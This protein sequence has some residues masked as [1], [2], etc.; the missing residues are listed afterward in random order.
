MPAASTKSSSLVIDKASE[1]SDAVLAL[2]KGIQDEYGLD[3]AQRLD[4]DGLSIHIPGVVSTGSEWLDWALGRGGVAMSRITLVSGNEG[5]GK[6]TLCL[7]LVAAVQKMGGVAFYVDAEYKLDLDYA[8]A[9]GVDANQMILSQPKTVEGAFAVID[10]ACD[11]VTT[12]RLKTG[13]DVPTLIILDSY[14]ALPAMVEVAVGKDK[15]GKD[16]NPAGKQ[17]PGAQARAISEQLRAIT[18]KLSK[19]HIALVLISQER[20]VFAGGAGNG[21]TTTGGNA[22]RF[23]AA[24][25]VSLE[26]AGFEKDGDE[27]IGRMT[28]VKVEKN[29]VGPPFRK[30]NLLLNYGKGIDYVH[31]L[32]HA[33]KAMFPEA[34]NGTWVHF[35]GLKW[36]GEQQLKQLIE[37]DPGN[38]ADVQTELRARYG[39]DAE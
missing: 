31:S 1:Q 22:P 36:Q 13:K 23:Y 32:H 9:L 35:A 19:S 27:K 8:I 3:A 25:I 4:S 7:H 37:D 12:M 39:W 6:T 20:I 5:A 38:L 29:Q 18:G 15:Y 11:V 16:K 2:L 21:A 28:Q 34:V 26:A 30:C 14:S 17:H 24:V 10:K 33:V